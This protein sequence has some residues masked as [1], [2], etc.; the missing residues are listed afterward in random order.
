MIDQVTIDR[1]VET[2]QGQIVDV[3]SE[4]VSLKKRGSN[5]LGHCPFHNEKTPSFIVSPYRGIFKC[6]GCGKG[7]NAV[8]F[9]MEHEQISFVEAIKHLGQ[10]FNIPVEEKDVSPELMQVK[11]ER[12]SMMV[13]T[14][15]AQKFFERSLFETDEGQSIGLSYFRNRGFRDDIIKKFQLGYSPEQRD[16]FTQE[17]LKN[18]F[19]IEFLEKTGLTIVKDDYKADRF[20]GRVMFP[21]HNLT[22]KAIAFGGRILKTDAKTAKYL[23]SPESE[24]YHKSRILYGIYQ[25][26][27]EIVREDKCYLVEGYTD[28]IS[29]HQAG[30]T[31]VV[32]S[33]GT[34]LTQDQIRLIARFT[35]NIT[36]LYD[37][38]PAGIKASLRG[39]DLILEEGMNVK[40]ML[41]PNGE[42]PD[43]FSRKM[44]AEELRSYIRK[45]ETDFIKFKTSLLLEDAKNDPIKRATLIQDIVRTIS[46]IPE[47]ITRS[48]YVKECS[49]L[50]NVGEDVLYSELAKIKQQKIEQYNK[51]GYKPIDISNT[52]KQLIANSFTTQNPFEIEEREVL[53]YLV[54]YG[55]YPLQF[56]EN[57]SITISVGEFIVNE[58]K[59]DDLQSTNEIHNRLLELFAN[60]H[61]KG[62]ITTSSDRFFINHQD[63][64]V[65][66]LATDLISKPYQLSKIHHKFGTVKKE[67]D[68]L[69]EIVPKVVLELK[70][71]KVMSIIDENH[72]KIKIAQDN[73]N[74]E[75]LLSLMK[76]HQKWLN[77]KKELANLLGNRIIVK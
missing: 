1:V 9:L 52:P 3:V 5:Y 7:G 59:Q 64:E 17:A 37:G 62:L 43:S 2:A 13:A 11:N 76:E 38:D 70:N 36:V 40:V 41:L 45:N 72:K 10:K 63:F 34:A 28:V 32:A 25:A 29:M 77:I 58:L 47:P 27:Q 16:A 14:S 23:N 61:N 57:D 35:P 26:K 31:N 51:T 65:S 48:V 8:H 6:F 66:Q 67:E 39:I 22:G 55:N 24:I 20:R 12:E 68:A 54:R 4:F 50:L 46:T 49:V 33:S 15:F 74:D 60:A 53:R 56:G 19:K 69:P 42:D 18:S 44:N 71:K 75:E 21:I 73:R 30:I